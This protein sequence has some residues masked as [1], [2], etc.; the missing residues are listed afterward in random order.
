MRTTTRTLK[1]LAV[2][3]VGLVCFVISQD[4]SAS[5]GRKSILVLFPYESNMPGFINFEAGFRSTLAGSKD[6]QFDFYVECM[7]LT[8][9]PDA[10]Y[11]DKLMELYREKYSSLKLDLI[12]ADRRPALDF[13][14]E[15]SPESFRNVPVIFFSQ[16][17]GLVGDPA[18]LR[19]QTRDGNIRWIEHACRP[20]TD[21]RGGFRGIRASNRD[22]TERRQMLDE[23]QGAAEEWQATFESITDLIML[24]DR[25][26]RILRVNAATV[27]FH[28]LPLD[29]ILGK[30]CYN[31]LHGT[32]APPDDC[33]FAGMLENGEHGEAVLHDRNR[34]AWLSVSIDPICND[35]KEITGVV[36]TVKDV[37]AHKR[38]EETIRTSEEFNRAVL[39][40]LKNHVAILDKN[41]MD[42]LFEPFYTTKAD[43]LGM[44]LSIS[45]TI[46]KAHNGTIGAENNPEG[47]ATFYFTLPVDGGVPS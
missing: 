5:A 39:T 27:A 41:D 24:L 8:R 44:G 35:R 9:F 15:Y 10:R 18:P 45:R 26:Y 32:V 7:D 29:D 17:P 16:D 20:V 28:G 47:G 31:V 22:I 33:P 42:R 23:I 11:H 25:E 40:S 2:L 19:I 14:S 36:H 21:E 46:I 34:N 1:S 6:L 12:V 37:T 30:H 38:A 13:L 3:I 43:G 4:S